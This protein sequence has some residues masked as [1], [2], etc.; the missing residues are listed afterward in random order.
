M[1]NAVSSVEVA[2]G[3]QGDIAETG[4]TLA[5]VVKV[6]GDASLKGNAATEQIK[7]FGDMTAYAVRMKAFRNVGELNTALGESIGAAKGA[8]MNYRDVLTT[9]AG[10]QQVGPTGSMAGEALEKSLQAIGR[11]GFQKLGVQVA[12]FNNGGMDVIGT[13]INLKRRFDKGAIS[14]ANF[15]RR[16][17]GATVGAQAAHGG[18]SPEAERAIRAALLAAEPREVL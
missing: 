10:F 8:G 3:T 14:I 13:L 1:T 2:K 7:R 15:E 12:R 4:H 5:Q 9:L 6:F 18:L 17:K 16:S 11:G